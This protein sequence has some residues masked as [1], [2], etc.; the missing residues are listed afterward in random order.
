MIAA[1]TLKIR[2][3]NTA[4]V[5]EILLPADTSSVS[6]SI[7]PVTVIITDVDPILASSK[8]IEH[9]ISKYCNF[10]PDSIS[11]NPIRGSMS[12]IVSEVRALLPLALSFISEGL[13]QQI[14]IKVTNYTS[15]HI[16]LGSLPLDPSFQPLNNDWKLFQEADVVKKQISPSYC[17]YCKAAGHLNTAK[18]P[19][20]V[21][22]ARN[23]DIFCSLCRKKGHPR[24]LCTARNICTVC[25]DS[26]HVAEDIKA[27]KEQYYPSDRD[28]IR[29]PNHPLFLKQ[30]AYLEKVQAS[31]AAKALNL[32]SFPAPTKT[33]AK[34]PTKDLSNTHN[35]VPLLRRSLLKP[36]DEWREV[37]PVMDQSSTDREDDS[38]PDGEIDS[39][40]VS[41]RLSNLAKDPP[42]VTQNRFSG[43][44]ETEDVCADKFEESTSEQVSELQENIKKN[45]VSPKKLSKRAKMLKKRVSTQPEPQIDPITEF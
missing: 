42:I 11:R 45:A 18:S 20:P 13:V 40:L 10:D 27:C 1:K 6:D 5:F 9:E 24:H 33:S 28:L 43:V 34:S 37:I 17:T 22:V 15:E 14:Q 30:K 25:G 39:V 31:K 7:L 21:S 38:W 16:Q 35:K 26:D 41:S 12:I 4:H 44:L 36:P 19:C 23:A 8:I 29:Y 2:E 3:Q 32:S